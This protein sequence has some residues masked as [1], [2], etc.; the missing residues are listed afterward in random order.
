MEMPQYKAVLIFTK[1]SAYAL[2]SEGAVTE[3][4]GAREAGVSR[5]GAPVAI[6]PGSNEMIFLGQ[7]TLN[8][9]RIGTISA[10]LAAHRAAQRRSD[11]R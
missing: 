6:I 8:L 5:L 10:G 2:Q 9:L 11:T 3:V 1:A 7:N 4:L